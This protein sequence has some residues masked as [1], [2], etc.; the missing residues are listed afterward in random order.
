[1]AEIIDKEMSKIETILCLEGGWPLGHVDLTV[2]FIIKLLQ[3]NDKVLNNMML[4]SSVFVKVVNLFKTFPFKTFLQLDVIKIFD[5]VRRC[6]DAEFRAAVLQKSR[7]GD[8]IIEM[9]RKPKYVF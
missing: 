8:A 7:I 1:M 2:K 6:D 4:E 5:V 9:A 3:L